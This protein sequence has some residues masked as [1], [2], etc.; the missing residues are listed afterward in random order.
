MTG[1]KITAVNFGGA[2]Y[3]PT[4]SPDGLTLYLPNGAGMVLPQTGGVG[5]TGITALGLG[6]LILAGAVLL[7]QKRKGAVSKS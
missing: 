4:I 2:Q 7:Y 5:T 1:A 6:L 3:K